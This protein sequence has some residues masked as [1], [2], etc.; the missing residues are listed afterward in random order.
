MIYKSN[1]K[2]QEASFKGDSGM[3]PWARRGFTSMIEI[4]A[5]WGKGTL[6][7]K[8]RQVEQQWALQKEASSP[9]WAELVHLG[10]QAM[11]TWKTWSSLGQENTMLCFTIL[12]FATWVRI[13]ESG[14]GNMLNELVAYACLSF[15]EMI[16]WPYCAISMAPIDIYLN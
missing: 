8:S 11:L 3:Y 13:Y 5:V 6:D 15:K 12:S 7:G 1:R 16:L 14:V 4:I 10:Q 2:V 9:Q